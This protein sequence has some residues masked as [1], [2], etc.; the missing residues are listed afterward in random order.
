[1]YNAFKYVDHDQSG[2]LNKREIRRALNMWKIDM[3]TDKLMDVIKACD[4]DGS[5][6]IDYGE[7]VE[8]L[9]RAGVSI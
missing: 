6:E 9:S 8:A 7:F 5:G 3:P 2:T 1:M 4:A